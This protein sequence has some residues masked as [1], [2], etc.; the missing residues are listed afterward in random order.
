V[1]RPRLGLR[2][3][4]LNRTSLWHRGTPDL[5]DVRIP[6]TDVMSQ[7]LCTRMECR[8]GLGDFT[9]SRSRVGSG[10]GARTVGSGGNSIAFAKDRSPATMVTFPIPATSNAAC[11]FPALRFPV[12]FMSRVIGPITLGALSAQMHDE[13]DSH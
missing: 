7:A 4:C 12:C 10:A 1:T 6:V 5:V 2:N 9:P 11:G 8:V 3:V 13:P